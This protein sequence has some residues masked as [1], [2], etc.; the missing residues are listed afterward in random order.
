MILRIFL[1]VFLISSFSWAMESSTSNTISIMPIIKPVT[2]LKS[3]NDFALDTTISSQLVFLIDI[4]DTILCR[5][6]LLCYFSIESRIGFFEKLAEKGQLENDPSQFKALAE[7]ISLTENPLNE[8][9]NHANDLVEVSIGSF[10]QEWKDRGAL[11]IG[12]TARHF[13]IADI[14]SKELAEFNIDFGSL[15]GCADVTLLDPDPSIGFKDGIWYTG[16]KQ[17]KIHHVPSVIA[18]LKCKVNA[19][20]PFVVVP[21]D[22]SVKEITAYSTV[23]PT[24]LSF[25]DQVTIVPFHYTRHAAKLQDIM[26]DDEQFFHVIYMEIATILSTKK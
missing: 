22:D 26:A 17:H 3:L 2:E 4:D 24:K 10:L 14:T 19:S 25:E 13:T 7:F 15:S 5:Y 23:D 8:N 11:I 6:A 1:M 21:V 9:Y 12:K 16:N 18:M 20:G